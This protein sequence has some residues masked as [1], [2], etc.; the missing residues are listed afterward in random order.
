MFEGESVKQKDEKEKNLPFYFHK[1]G[2]RKLYFYNGLE[3]NELKDFLEVIKLNTEST[4]KDSDMVSSLWEKKFPHIGYFA[5]DD[6]IDTEIGS[7]EENVK[8]IKPDTSKLIKGKIPIKPEDQP[9]ISDDVNKTSSPFPKVEEELKK[10]ESKKNYHELLKQTEEAPVLTEEEANRLNKMIAENR[11]ISQ[12]SELISLI[13]EILNLENR[14]EHFLSNIKV[15]EQC[16]EEVINELDFS[17]ATIIINNT[18]EL[19]KKS[20]GTHKEKENL[21]K[22]FINNA[23]NKQ[24]QIELKK[25]FLTKD[26]KNIDALFEYLMSLGP[27][28]LFFINQIYE[29]V[30]ESVMRKKIIQFLNQIV[31]LYTD[32]VIHNMHS[33]KEPFLHE[34]ISIIVKNQDEKIAP[35]IKELAQSDNKSFRLGLIKSLGK[36]NDKSLNKMLLKFLESSD[37]DIR[38]ESFK[39]L[40]YFGDKELFTIVKN[41][42]LRKYFKRKSDSEKKAILGFLGKTH[43]IEA[44]DF[45]YQILK[46]RRSLFSLKQIK[47][48]L[49]VIDVLKALATPEAIEILTEGANI[50]NKKVRKACQQ[51][52]TSLPIPEKNTIL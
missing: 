5:L 11:K 47:T 19:I 12:L 28:T 6:Y 9:Q 34:L 51:A 24:S 35:F 7:I 3:E 38:T 26:I 4:A 29:E 18:K 16:L 2:I 27:E 10:E 43:L 20:E 21:L 15:L 39:N 40:K 22:E 41:H 33:Y 30:T 37:A 13:F 48:R 8:L 45:L 31:P 14:Y 32:Y 23:K 44:Y 42:A 52:L 50:K 17:Y 36:T 25:I 1:D 46:E 49:C